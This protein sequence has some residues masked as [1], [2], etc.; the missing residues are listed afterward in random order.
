M[1]VYIVSQFILTDLPF[2]I[3][4]RLAY[5]AF[6]P[7]HRKVLVHLRQFF[8]PKM[9]EKTEGGPP[10]MAEQLDLAEFTLERITHAVNLLQDRSI[11]ERLAFDIF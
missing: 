1:C 8:D 9:V 2:L 7:L 3:F 4:L 5:V 10:G 6:S 11:I